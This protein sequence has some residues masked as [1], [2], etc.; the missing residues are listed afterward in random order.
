MSLFTHTLLL[1]FLIVSLRRFVQSRHGDNDDFVS[2]DQT[3]LETSTITGV[4]YCLG[5]RVSTVRDST[6][7]LSYTSTLQRVLNLN[8]IN[9]SGLFY[10]K[11]GGSWFPLL[12]GSHYLCSDRRSTWHSGGVPVPGCLRSHSSRY[13]G[14]TPE[15]GHW[16][17]STPSFLKDR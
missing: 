15:W 4:E 5:K 16:E 7:V 14:Y 3:H 6:V 13:W 2:G 8:Q 12:V 9:K 10:L 17:T 11:C 1:V